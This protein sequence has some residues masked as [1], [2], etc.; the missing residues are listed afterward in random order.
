MSTSNR[1][2]ASVGP[3][4]HRV[5]V[6]ERKRGGNVYLISWDAAA[7][8]HRKT[9]LGFPVRDAEGDLI[10]D[11]VERA[12]AAA[13]EASNALIRGATPHERRVTVG[14]AADLFRREEV[15]DMSPRHEKG[16]RRDL[17]LIERHL[18]RGFELEKLGPREWNA[19][20]RDRASGRIDSRGNRVPKKAD[21]RER[22]AR[23]V[24]KTLKVLRQLC[25]FAARWR[26][27]DGSFLLD[28]DPTRGL[29]LPTPRDQ[30]RPVCSDELLAGLLEAAPRVTRRVRGNGENEEAET[31][32]RELILVAAG[33]G[34]RIG[35]ILQLKWSDWHPD[36]GTHGTLRWRGEAQKNGRTRET[37][38]PPSVREALEA[39]RR[40]RPG[41]GEAP[42]FPAPDSKG[43][44]R[45]DVALDWLQE[46]E[47]EA[48]P[49]GE[50]VK[51][52][53]WH[54][55]RRRWANKMKDRPAV[56][57]AY[58]GGWSGPHVMET[59]YQRADQQG[60]ERA[61][62]AGDPGRVAAAGGEA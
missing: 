46:A 17:T 51:G 16:V 5:R 62:A 20:K 24:Q 48:R 29:D 31:C 13:A 53:G 2:S 8:R 3:H 44:L 28:R 60:M 4:G 26:R 40:R 30:R 47:E 43:A 1:W 50:H 37:P 22:S 35:S 36:R 27:P 12:E 45:V 21:R 55:L 57:V 61:L 6:E 34:A 59:V 52:F 58:L 42:V 49:D 33:T 32:L 56:D 9:S 54:A 10:E 18:G 41:V 25:R 7:G 38:V 39:Q 14:E 19:I 11:A 23:T 15:S